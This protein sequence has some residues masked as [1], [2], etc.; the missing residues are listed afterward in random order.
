MVFDKVKRAEGCK[1]T[2]EKGSQG[3]GG[4]G[5]AHVGGMN[6]MQLSPNEQHT[7]ES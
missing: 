4:G 7:I 1:S 2:H 6:S 5:A 3:G